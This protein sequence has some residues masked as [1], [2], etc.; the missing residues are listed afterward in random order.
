MFSCKSAE[1]VR[2]AHHVGVRSR[3][4]RICEYLILGNH[5]DTRV[6]VFEPFVRVVG[7]VPRVEEVMAKRRRGPPMDEDRS[8][9]IDGFVA[10]LPQ[11]LQFLLELGRFLPLVFQLGDDMS[12]L[13]AEA[14]YNN[15][16][17]IGDIDD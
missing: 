7:K 3:S 5:G 14:V 10:V 9:L 15:W 13:C 12:L 1:V 6:V 16:R 17:G 11:V 2:R 4:C 8:Q